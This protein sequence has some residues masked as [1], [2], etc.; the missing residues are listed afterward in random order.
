M[1]YKL[2]TYINFFV[3]TL[4]FLFLSEFDYSYRRIYWNFLIIFFFKPSKHY[5]NLF[6][7]QSLDDTLS[8][9]QPVKV[10]ENDPFNQPL[11]AKL[12]YL[13]TSWSEWTQCSKSCGGGTRLRTRTC[14]D[15]NSLCWG[16]IKPEQFCNVDPCPGVYFHFL[17]TDSWIIHYLVLHS[18]LPMSYKSST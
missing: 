17:Q 8:Y 16:E 2:R 18:L 3:L 10:D 15:K 11:N 5:L 13:Y 7:I 12:E 14:K 6:K 1:F 4:I 9:F